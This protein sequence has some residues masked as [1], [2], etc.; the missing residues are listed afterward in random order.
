MWPGGQVWKPGPAYTVQWRLGRLRRRFGC[1]FSVAG[2]ADAGAAR[3][4]KS[5]RIQRSRRAPHRT[6]LRM[7]FSRFRCHSASTSTRSQSHALTRFR[8]PCPVGA[9]HTSP[10]CKPWEST[11]QHSSRSEGTPHSL[12]A[13]DIDPAL[14]MRCSF[15]TH[16]LFRMRFPGR[17][18]G[19]VCVAPLGQMGRWRF[20][21]GV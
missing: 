6:S 15:R 3:S 11:R 16:L 17:C 9:S 4:V 1:G 19:L 5:Y 2:V 14:P 20:R 21:S 18:P 12:P 8:T 10:G 7:F 13:S